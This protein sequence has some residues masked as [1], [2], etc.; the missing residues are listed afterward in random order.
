MNYDMETFNFGIDEYGSELTQ[1]SHQTLHWLNR[2]GYLS[3]EDTEDLVSRMIVTPIRNRPRLGQRLLARF[4][5]KESADN[6]YVFPITLVD[7]VYAQKNN[8]GEDKPTLKVVK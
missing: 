5:N 1:Q 3:N 4:F 7:D 8:G 6:S 2:N